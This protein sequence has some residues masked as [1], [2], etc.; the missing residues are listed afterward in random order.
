MKLVLMIDKCNIKTSRL[1]NN[2]SINITDNMQVVFT[3]DALEELIKDF[4]L[5]KKEIEENV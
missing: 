1:G 3:V 4:T 5:I 2:I